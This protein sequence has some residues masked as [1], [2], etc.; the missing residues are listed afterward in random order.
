ME[1][2]K[3]HGVTA[4]NVVVPNVCKCLPSVGRDVDIGP[5]LTIFKTAEA[6]AR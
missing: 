3:E 4:F 1:K 6:P 2:A 5:E